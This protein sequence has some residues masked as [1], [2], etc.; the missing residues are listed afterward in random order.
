MR[1]LLEIIIRVLVTGDVI[2][3]GSNNIILGYE[4][5]LSAN[6]G[7][8]QIVIGNDAVGHGDNIAVIGNTDCTAWHPADDNGVDLGSS[9]ISLK[10][11]ILWVAYLD[12]IT[13]TGDL[14]ITGDIHIRV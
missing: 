6:S 10:T 9:T 7:T 5:D 3:T 13:S 8:N 14:S 1:L 4:G 12:D 2:T 11:F